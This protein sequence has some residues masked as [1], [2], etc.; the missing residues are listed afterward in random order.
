MRGILIIKSKLGLVWGRVLLGGSVRR[1]RGVKKIILVVV[2][3]SFLPV[4][5]SQ[6][7]TKSA[8]G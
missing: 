5:N 2:L 3:P 1:W 8:L 4:I 7:S 6:S